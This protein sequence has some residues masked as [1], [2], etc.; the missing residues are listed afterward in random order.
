MK[1]ETSSFNEIMRKSSLTSLQ[2]RLTQPLDFWSYEFLRSWINTLNHIC[3][4]NG[5]KIFVFA[6]MIMLTVT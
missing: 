5:K 4:G 3:I 1:E 2:Y 6:F